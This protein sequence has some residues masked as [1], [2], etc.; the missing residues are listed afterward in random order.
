M[1]TPFDIQHVKI[2][3]LY[4]KGVPAGALDYAKA[5]ARRTDIKVMHISHL[6]LQIVLRV[7]CNAQVI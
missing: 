6:L 4:S 1:N 3:Q 7:K 5:S 2:E